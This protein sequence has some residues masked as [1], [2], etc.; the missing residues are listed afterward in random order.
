M[1]KAVEEIIANAKQQLSF[2]KDSIEDLEEN[3]N[4]IRIRKRA[5]ANIIIFGRSVTFVLQNL[6]SRV[7]GFDE[8]YV[9]I[10][11]K[12]KGDE[13]LNTFKN[14][15]NDLEK[16][17]K[18]NSATSISIDFLDGRMMAE[19]MK[20]P[21]KNAKSFF[22]GDTFGGS[23]WFVE[24]PDGT[25]EKLYVEIGENSSISI[26]VFFSQRPSMHNGQRITDSTIENCSRL[27]YEFLR[28]L[29]DEAEKKFKN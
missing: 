26:D 9:P 13:L 1:N 22:I 25:E 24:M 28:S 2:I 15:R 4:N 7:F 12:M 19:L 20:N 6:R 5:F 21:P 3:K 23:G 14:A 27:Y 16:Q 29:V 8:W 18:I 11:E 17:G 10:Q